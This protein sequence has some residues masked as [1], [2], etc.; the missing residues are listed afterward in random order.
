M[1]HRGSDRRAP[2]RRRAGFIAG[3]RAA[4]GMDWFS[5]RDK[6]V[7]VTGG[8]RGLGLVLTRR[9]ALLGARVAILA[10]DEECLARARE[11]VRRRGFNVL[12]V[13]CDVRDRAQVQ[14]AVRTVAQELG[15]VDVLINNAGVIQVGPMETMTQEDY[16]DAMRTHFWGPLH[17]T[18]AVLPEMRRR[19][20]GRI[21]NI[22]S[23]GGKVALP[24]IL[25]YVA[26]KFALVGL[27]EGMRTE[28]LQEGITVTTVCPGLI[29]TGSVYNAFFKGR[30]RAEASWFMIPASLPVLSMSVESAASMILFATRLGRA[31]ITPGIVANI[32]ARVHGMFPG[33]TQ[34]ALGFLNR[35]LPEPD[36]I[37]TRRAL[38]RDS[39]TR[40]TSSVLTFLTQRAARA[41]NQ[42]PETD[43]GTTGQPRVARGAAEPGAAPPAATPSGG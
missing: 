37:G 25:P 9:L 3:L 21:V 19:G 40:L 22:S 20:R 15:P 24:H 31:E 6:V 42:L 23:V 33:I 11:D 34:D 35:M 38:G 32:A 5:F 13:R 26:S 8:S 36:G 43:L 39:L 17:A 28:L 7:I 27:S 30:H 1:E 12:A 2:V 18:Q 29:R 4:L 10:R 14:A 41:N 16:E